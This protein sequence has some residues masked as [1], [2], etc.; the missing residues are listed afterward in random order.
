MHPLRGTLI[1]KEHGV[2]PYPEG[3]ACAQILLAG[4]K[5]K[6]GEASPS[7]TVLAGIGTAAALK[8]LTDGLRVF[9][10]VLT[11]KI[12]KLWT[13]FSVETYPAIVSV[14]YI[15]GLR[16]CSYL[17]AGGLL[18]W[19]VLIPA[20]MLFGENNVLFP[21]TIPITEIYEIGGARMIW[22]T[23][24]RYI[25]AGAVAAAGFISLVKNIP[26]IA[27]AFIKSMKGLKTENSDPEIRT[28]RSLKR[29]YVFAGLVFAIIL[30]VVI[31][32]VHLD[33]LGAILV[34]L[35]AFFF[36]AVASRVAGI[37]GST[38]TPV[39]GMVI[40]TLLIS[41][42]LLKAGGYDM[43]SVMLGAISIGTIVSIASAIATDISQDLK[44]G[45]LLGAT[46]WKQQAG[47][48]I[49]VT[50]AGAV[51]GLVLFALDS[52][53][54]FG[55]ERLPAPQAMLMKMIVEGIVEGDL[56]WM[57]VIIGA[58]IAVP[59]ELMSIPALPFTIGLYLPLELSAA[60]MLG[61]VLRLFVDKRNYKSAEEKEKSVSSSILCCS[62][63]IAG[64][65]IIG[66]FLAGLA[67][68]PAQG[69]RPLGAI[70]ES[71]GS[72][73]SLGSIGGALSVAVVAFMILRTAARYP[74][75]KPTSLR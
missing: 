28:N 70:F 7:L 22:S 17:F 37:I 14:G 11:I 51:M 47:E 41:T 42:L 55:S 65:G 75:T 18:T 1:V 10:G 8:F 4:E 69:G 49:G 40:A 32:S 38:N 39:S 20:I 60:T 3:T 64:E 58:L 5:R 72:V 45:H 27:G 52:A 6:K 44:T 53:W 9:S 50:A 68:I 13:Q 63:M 48:I 57:L 29:R 73:F 67:V 15:C 59:L 23:Y 36:S 34:L 31:P 66:I 35:F 26:L 2:L 71:V 54:G 61:G 56:P 30:I 62:G 74:S 16:I 12:P 25:G 33:V 21:G 19:V 46:P 24:I 43:V